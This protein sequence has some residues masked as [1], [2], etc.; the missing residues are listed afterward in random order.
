MCYLCN[1]NFKKLH[2]KKILLWLLLITLFSCQKEST[3]NGK[4]LLADGSL[5]VTN[6]ETGEKTKYNHFGDGKTVSQLTA[7]DKPNYKLEVI[8]QNKTTWTIHGRDFILNDDTANPMYLQCISSGNYRICENP[9]ATELQL[10]GSSRPFKCDYTDKKGD[11]IEVCI[12]DQV[13][14]INGY[15]CEWKSVLYFKRIGK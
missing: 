15:N 5:Y 6:M 11:Y 14:S 9:R 2:M 1:I 7:Y 10:G 4:W 12:Q 3:L 13:G 8:E